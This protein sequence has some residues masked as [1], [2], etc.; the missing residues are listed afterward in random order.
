SN[1]LIKYEELI[2]F[3]KSFN[4][5][6]TL[7][8][9]N[10]YIKI[11]NSIINSDEYVSKNVIFAHTTNGYGN[12][13]YAILT[14]LV[15][16]VLTESAVII[17]WPG[18]EQFINTPLKNIFYDY[19]QTSQF[20]INYKNKSNNF[21][22]QS[23][24]EYSWKYKKNLDY[25][26]NYDLKTNSNRIVIEKVDALF[27]PICAKEKNFQKLHNYGLLSKERLKIAQNALYNELELSDSDRINDLYMVGFEVAGN[28]L[29]LVWKI[30]PNLQKEID[31][32]YHEEFYN[33]FVIGIQFRF[34]FL[35]K[36]DISKFIE[37]ANFIEKKN[38]V[39]KV[40]WFVTS[41]LD[42]IFEILDQ[43]FG[44]KII[45]GKG[46]I[47]HIE[48]ESRNYA[49]TIMDAELMS[50]SNEII[51]TGGSTFGFLS[52]I[53][54]KILPYFIEGK[55]WSIGPCKRATFNYGPLNPYGYS[56]V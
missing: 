45:S 27:F 36:S 30:Q 14:A 9:F 21:Y 34:E 16:G 4:V 13:I 32:I 50:R 48:Y 37:C 20:N 31:K 52:A 43:E 10:K 28:L 40:K 25:L 3:D 8:K 49:R 2:N 7:K 33:Y 15:L 41:E 26:L 1:W 46:R 23:D 18:I 17:K 11:H 35:K 47:G 19:P 39:K 6:T 56:I 42:D 24:Y 53:K 5:N 12:K 22:F 51:I 44:N 54:K 55:R 29:N 38:N